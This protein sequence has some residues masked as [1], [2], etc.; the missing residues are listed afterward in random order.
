MSEFDPDVMKRSL[1][2]DI[3]GVVDQVKAN[4]D[5]AVAQIVGEFKD[6]AK[7]VVADFENQNYTEDVKAAIQKQTDAFQEDL[8]QMDTTL[9]DLRDAATKAANLA[10]AADSADLKRAVADLVQQSNDL[11]SKLK[12]FKEKTANFGQKVGGAIATAAV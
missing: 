2:E 4:V 1:P 6:N 10:K 8:K 9:A 7:K 11:Q 3:H 12:D 5:L